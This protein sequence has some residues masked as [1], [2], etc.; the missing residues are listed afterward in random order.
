MLAPFNVGVGHERRGR[1][2]WQRRVSEPG[3]NKY[4]ARTC[5]PAMTRSSVC[6]FT[7]SLSWGRRDESAN[8]LHRPRS[9]FSSL[10]S[11]SGFRQSRARFGWKCLVR[12]DR[13][14][15]LIKDRKLPLLTPVASSHESGSAGAQHTVP[16]H[17]RLRRRQGRCL[18][19]PMFGLR[20]RRA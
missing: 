19:S 4:H 12:S 3:R 16:C 1:G 18:S 10:K 9:G 15:I 6:R 11:L 2:L 8:V 14:E 7:L 5:D 20:C 13:P 17:L